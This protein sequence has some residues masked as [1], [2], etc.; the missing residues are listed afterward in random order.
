MNR[1]RA[2]FALALVIA[3]GLG[4]RSHFTH[5]WPAL[6]TK[7]AGDALW[8]TAIFMLLRVC[9]PR[10]PTARLAAIALA[11]STVVELTQLYHAPWIEAVRATW[12]GGIALGHGFHVTD[13]VWYTLGTLL[14]IG[15]DQ[16]SRR[17]TAIEHRPA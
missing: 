12:L 9:F 4:V 13:L 7:A 6:L 3:A 1:L 11:I 2:V 14:G 8:T 10:L 16:L 5:G 17:V 15:L